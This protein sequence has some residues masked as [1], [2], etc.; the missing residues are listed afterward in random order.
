MSAPAKALAGLVGQG[1]SSGSSSSVHLVGQS[2]M[3][4]V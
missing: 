2:A 1:G 4:M 3:E